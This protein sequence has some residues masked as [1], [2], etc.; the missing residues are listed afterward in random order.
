MKKAM[1][2]I[3][4]TFVRDMQICTAD[5]PDCGDDS[6]KDAGGFNLFVG[7]EYVDVNENIKDTLER[8]SEEFGI[9]VKAFDY[10]WY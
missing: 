4:D 1:I 5:E 7:I 3:K 2:F 8:L 10:M 9:S 6:W